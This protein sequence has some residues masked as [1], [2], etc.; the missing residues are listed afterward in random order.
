MEVEGMN[1]EL[2]SLDGVKFQ[3][4]AYSV[5]LPTASGQITLLER[6]EPL[7]S[8][9]VPGTITIRREKNDADYKL[10]HYA[11]FGGVL[12]VNKEGARVLVDEAEHGDEIS[13][14]EAKKAHDAA[15]A[16]LKQA[17]NQVELEK[18][19]SLVDRQAVRLDVAQLRHRHRRQR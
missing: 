14:A 2:V 12:E 16:M 7:L 18:A 15:L 17:K 8:V 3:A 19:Q 9:V 10:E 6:H 5:I 1:F 4:K 13:E 11:T